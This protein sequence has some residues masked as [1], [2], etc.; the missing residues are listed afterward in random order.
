MKTKTSKKSVLF[1][2]LNLIFMGCIAQVNFVFNAN[3]FGKDLKGLS[4]VQILN[5]SPQIYT[6]NLDIQIKQLSNNTTFVRVFVEGLNIIA[7][8]NILPQYKLS[9]ASTFY[10]GSTDGNYAKQTSMLPEGE[11]EYCFKFTVTS[12]TNVGEVFE[13]CFMGFNTVST[14]LNLTAPDNGDKF[15][16]K[17]PRF[18]WQPQLPIQ[19][20]TTYSLKLVEVKQ[21]QTLAEALLVNIPI[22]L[23]NNIKGYFALYPAN[24]ASLKEKIKY[25]WQITSNNNGKLALSEVW[26]FTIDC[27][28]DKIE[29][30]SYREINEFDNMGVLIANDVLRFAIY[31]AYI[32]QKLEY[33]L[34]DVEN[35]SKKIKGLPV[36]DLTKGM[37]NL[38]INLN[39]VTGIEIDKAY[40]LSVTLPNG[41]KASLRIKY[42]DINE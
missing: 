22:I 18:S 32:N 9:A 21:E 5:T 39:Q 27:P 30:N 13:N 7:G 31:N 11:L 37:N 24:V 35:P 10:S 14:P 19:T 28:L 34:I 38:E 4:T 42:N 2:V 8:N 41:K 29:N 16:N 1:I 20:G 23:Q 17:R 26:E 36:L 12:K 33:S 40:I 15:C 3:A 6:G 25:A